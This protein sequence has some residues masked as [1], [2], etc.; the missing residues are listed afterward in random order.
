[1]YEEYRA[2]GAIGAISTYLPLR[3]SGYLIPKGKMPH[4]ILDWIAK[5]FDIIISVFIGLLEV[6]G[7]FAKV[8]SLGGRLFGNMWAG[9]LLLAIAVSGGIALTS[10]L[11]GDI[12]AVVP[13]IV[14]IQALFVACIQAF[15][16]TLLL[17]IF[18]KL[19]YEH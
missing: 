4:S 16:F 7:H 8:I 1:M 3:G 9:G 19:V 13:V 10:M 2:K 17:S 15:V 5:L 18:I 14:H 6:I 11:P 12:P